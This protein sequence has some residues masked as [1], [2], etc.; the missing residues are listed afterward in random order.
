M[1]IC[2]WIFDFLCYFH[3]THSKLVH[4]TPQSYLCIKYAKFHLFQGINIAS[5]SLFIR[6]NN[7]DLCWKQYCYQYYSKMKSISF[8]PTVIHNIPYTSWD[9]YMYNWITLYSRNWHNIVSQLYF[10]F[11]KKKRNKMNFRSSCCGS[12]E[13]KLTRNYEDTG[14]NPGL[15]QWVKDPVLWGV[16]IWVA[17]MAWNWYC[18]GCGAGQQL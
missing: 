18:C 8:I 6:R 2:F 11:L 3:F 1:L 10:N 16:R 5:F 14:S 15:A 17:N 9:M 4:P 12:A 7:H 13:T